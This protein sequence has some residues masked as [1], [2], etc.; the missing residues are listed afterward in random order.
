MFIYMVLVFCRATSFQQLMSYQYGNLLSEP[1]PDT[2]TKQKGPNIKQTDFKQCVCVGAVALYRPTTP[3][4]DMT[5]AGSRP[6][7]WRACDVTWR[8][9]M[10]STWKQRAAE[11]RGDVNEC[12]SQADGHTLIDYR[13]PAVWHQEVLLTNT[14]LKWTHLCKCS[15]MYTNVHKC[16]QMYTNVHKCTQ[17]CTCVYICVHTCAHMCTNVHTCAQM[18][19]CVK[20]L[21]T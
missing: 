5:L 7:R 19:T 14:V 15:Q 13:S 3:W 8:V 10:T 11:T 16:A 1:Y 2:K 18:C 6:C 21:S 17:M 12:V 9:R 4:R 20:I